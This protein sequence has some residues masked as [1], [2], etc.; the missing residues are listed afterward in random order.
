ML[1]ARFSGRR[2]VA[3]ARLHG[4]A[5]AFRGHFDFAESPA[6]GFIGRVSQVVLAAQF[7]LYLL[8]NLIDRHFLRDLEKRAAGFFRDPLQDFLA[9]APRLLLPWPAAASHSSMTAHS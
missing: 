3:V 5:F 6:V 7:F 4:E 1:F 9:V 8:V 2:E